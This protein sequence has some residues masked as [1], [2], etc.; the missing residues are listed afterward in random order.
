VSFGKK[1]SEMETEVTMMPT[2]TDP[3]L[4]KDGTTE[5]Y[6]SEPWPG[7]V[8]GTYDIPQLK[9]LLLDYLAQTTRTSSW[10]REILLPSCLKNNVLT[11]EQFRK[12]FV[13]LDPNC[14]ERTS[15]QRVTHV[16]TQLGMKTNDFL[17]QVIEYEYPHNH[18]KKDNFSIKGRY[19]QL[20]T[21]VLEQ[22]KPVGH[23]SWPIG[24]MR[25][26]STDSLRVLPR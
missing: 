17:R 26:E 4:K 12:A 8:P 25:S 7:D 22:L 21:E 10:M 9:Q 6:G 11:I 16:S 24:E 1:E 2:S 19:R 3:A 13:D 23:T 18:W 15:R 20:V 14:D 5:I